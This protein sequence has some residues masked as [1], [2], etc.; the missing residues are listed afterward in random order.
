LSIEGHIW[1]RL[2]L[3]F[4]INKIHLNI[5]NLE[6]FHFYLSLLYK[7][8]N[9]G[10]LCMFDIFLDMANIYLYWVYRR[11][12]LDTD[13]LV[14]KFYQNLNNRLSRS[15]RLNKNNI[16]NCIFYKKGYLLLCKKSVYKYTQEPILY[17][18]YL[19]KLCNL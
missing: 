13:N 3:M 19:Y 12:L 4:D 1:N 15:N 14:V 8:Y 2:Y 18:Q 7:K 17:L 16:Y 10:H 9:F 6:N 5:H 11:I